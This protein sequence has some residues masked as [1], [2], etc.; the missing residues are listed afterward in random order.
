VSKKAELKLDLKFGYLI[1]KPNEI[2]IERKVFE[3]VSLQNI[4]AIKNID[5]LNQFSQVSIKSN[6]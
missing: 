6:P 1:L 2:T 5:L 3:D 4:D